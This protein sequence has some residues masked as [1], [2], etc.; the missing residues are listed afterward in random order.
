ML[1]IAVDLCPGDILISKHG[2]YAVDIMANAERGVWFA[3][4]TIVI[5]IGHVDITKYTYTYKPKPDI[6][7]MI[8]GRLLFIPNVMWSLERCL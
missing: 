2:F 8:D 3:R 4:D 1:N 5:F 7:V 6:A